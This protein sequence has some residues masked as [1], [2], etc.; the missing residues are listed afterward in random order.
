MYPTPLRPFYDGWARYHGLVIDALRDLTREQ[1]DLRS[2]PH[3]WAVW[4]LAAHVAGSRA[5]WFHD[6][7][8]E[9]DASVRDLFRVD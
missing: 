7:L 8:G 3:P 9:G 2:A 4:Q 5:Y 1:L 6:I